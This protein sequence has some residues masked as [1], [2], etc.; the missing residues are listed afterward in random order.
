M[1]AAH[2]NA[3]RE[4]EK[5]IDGPIA[6]LLTGDSMNDTGAYDVLALIRQAL[7]EEGTVYAVHC[8]E[9]DEYIFVFDTLESAETFQRAKPGAD[10]YISREPVLTMEFALEAAALEESE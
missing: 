2:I 5:L 3:L 9:G 10:E 1:S 4:A 7:S 8:P 6:D